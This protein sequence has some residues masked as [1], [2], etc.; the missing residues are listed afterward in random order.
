M[1]QQGEDDVSVRFRAALSELREGKLSRESCELFC[2]QVANQLSPDE[3]STFDNALRLYFTREEVYNRNIQ[4]LTGRNMPIKILTIVNRGRDAEKATEDEAD[5]LPNKIYICIGARIM[6][7]SNLWTEIGLVN[8][9]MGTVVDI[10]WQLGQDP[11]TSLPFAI[12]I[13]F[14][15]YS[16]PVFLG[17]SAGIVLVFV[18]LH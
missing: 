18:G 1:R 10:M 13:R 2:T 5:N 8:G 15:E 6:L 16:G 7:S 9:S 3:V 4:C 14:D 11:T 17:C 12:L